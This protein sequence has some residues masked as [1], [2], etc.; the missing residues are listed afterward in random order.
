[1]KAQTLA[2]LY[3]SAEDLITSISA[4]GSADED[5]LRKEIHRLSLALNE[6]RTDIPDYD[7]RQNEE[8][9]PVANAGNEIDG[10]LTPST[11]G[12]ALSSLGESDL[13]IALSKLG[14]R[15]PIQV[16]D[17]RTTGLITV[18]ISDIQKIYQKQNDEICNISDAQTILSKIIKGYNPRLSIEQQCKSICEEMSDPGLALLNSF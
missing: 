11:L 17:K 9:I 15:T 12:L 1:M 13:K 8:V 16:V 14:E 10:N 7:S 6:A 5:T 3:D 2:E 18:T 4:F